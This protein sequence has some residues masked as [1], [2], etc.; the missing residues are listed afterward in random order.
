MDLCDLLILGLSLGFPLCS[1]SYTHPKLDLQTAPT[2]YCAS[3]YCASLILH[4]L[5]IEGSGNL[6]V[7]HV[8]WHHFSKSI[9]LLHVSV[10]HFDNSHNI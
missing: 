7:K 5:Q 8:Y 9:C 4:F 10:L 3:L 2:A 6:Y 1:I